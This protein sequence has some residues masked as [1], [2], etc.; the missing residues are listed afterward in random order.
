MDRISV[1][2]TT[3]NRAAVLSRTVEVLRSLVPAP[4]EILITADG[5]TDGT[6]EY[7]RQ[8]VPEARLFVNEVGRGSV[9]SRVKMMHE[10][11]GD[12]VL[13][14]DDDSYPEPEQTDCLAKVASLFAGRPRLAVA[15]FPQRSDEYP[16][17]LSQN[18]FG[19]PC[20][21]RSYAHSGACLRRSIYLSLPGFEPRFFHMGEEADYALQCLAAGY[22]VLYTP[23]IVIRHHWT[24]VARSELRNH[25]FAARNN[26]WSALLRC[27]FPFA[28]AVAGYKLL[29]QFRY[30]CSRGLAWALREPL[31]WWPALSGVG[32][33]LGRRTPMSWQDYQRF[34]RLPYSALKVQRLN[35][36][37]DQR[38]ASS[39]AQ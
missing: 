29:S 17:T 12:L 15:H 37:N 34:M 33:C 26:F 30:A 9:A 5:C 23:A 18:V 4:H 16:E 32:Y 22:E 7:V 11:T 13:A 21:T 36:G 19:P 24:K 20:L 1:M 10:A 38:V 2:I 39:P 27:P 6:V 14:L 35:I 25:H 31:W 8:S 28:P 3:R